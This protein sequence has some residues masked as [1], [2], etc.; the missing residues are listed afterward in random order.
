LHWLLYTG[1]HTDF[2][3]FGDFL[4]EL[5][6]D[7]VLIVGDFNILVDNEK[8]TLGSAFIDILKSIGV[9]QHMS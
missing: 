2:K 5:A 9:R 8:N 7:K 4:L 6:T 1:H 3:E